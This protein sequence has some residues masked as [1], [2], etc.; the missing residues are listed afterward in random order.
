M[1]AVVINEYGNVDKLQME[2]IT[3]PEIADDE[4]LVEVKA[5]SVNP[6]DWKLREGYLAESIPLK[7]PIILGWDVAGVITRTGRKV[8][9]FKTGDKVLAR[10]DLTNR[11]T[12]AEYTA[13]KEDKLALLPENVSY[14]EAAALPLAGMTAWQGVYDYL[15][16]KPGQKVLM[17][18]GAGGV[19]IIAIQL[20]KHIGAHVYTTASAKN[21]EF[22]KSLGAERVI[23]YHDTDFSKE[24]NDLDAVFD[25]VGGDT[26][27]KSY[28]VL[29]QGGRLITIAGNIDEDLAK[30]KDI[31]AQS[32]WLRPNGKQ[33]TQLVNLVSEGVVKVIIDS[34]HPFTQDGVKAAQEVSESHH[35]KGKIVISMK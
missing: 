12:Y 11:G 16:V 8:K 20:L 6:I 22:L 24:L 31:T 14:E 4:V 3:I 21:E 23:D 27:A 19:G 5:T 17:Q 35:A 28:S 33:L 13:V 30:A 25:T 7:F 10:P 2:N 1:K 29:K 32:I 18:G 9:E 34:T 26:L 15:E